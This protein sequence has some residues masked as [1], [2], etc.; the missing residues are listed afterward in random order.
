MK[1]LSTL[2]AFDDVVAKIAQGISRDYPG[3]EAEDVSQHLYLTILQNR[4]QFKNPDAAGVTGA[5]WSIG[6]QYAIQ[7]RAEH[8]H[9]SPQYAYRPEDVRKILE[10]TFDRHEWYD[11]AVPEDAKSLKASA[12]E[13]DLQSDIKWAWSQLHLEEMRVVFRRYALKEELG[14][15][16]R[17]KF[18]RSIEK[19]VDMVNTYPRPGHPRRAMSNTRAQ[20]II[21]GSYE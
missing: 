16:D 17:R 2:E 6:K 13:L 3:I 20:H 8:L 1:E 12:D 9:L 5:L 4:K 18:N 11:T 21:G 7:L 15:S 19:I 10:H 14:D